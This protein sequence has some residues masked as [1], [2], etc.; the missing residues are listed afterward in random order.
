MFVVGVLFVFL[1]GGCVVY[2]LWCECLILCVIGYIDV[3]VDFVEL[4][5]WVVL[6]ILVGG[7]V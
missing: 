4:C 6:I 7:L 1:L 3:C 2:C 5:L